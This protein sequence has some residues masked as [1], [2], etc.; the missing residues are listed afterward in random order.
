MDDVAY[1]YEDLKAYSLS[2]DR[3][4]SVLKTLFRD[5]TCLLW[6]KFL[7]SQLE[8]YQESIK[9][10]QLEQWKLLLKLRN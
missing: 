4:T 10:L 3:C 5:P 9:I 1:M 6:L 8:V 2:I 7:I